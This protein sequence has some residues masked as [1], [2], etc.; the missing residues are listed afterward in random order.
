MYHGV[1]FSFC[2]ALP[3][4]FHMMRQG[5][6]H[7]TPYKKIKQKIDK[8]QVASAPSFGLPPDHEEQSNRCHNCNVIVK[9]HNSVLCI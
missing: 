2:Q 8:M 6:P 9:T 3:V 4:V 5:L 1:I 7:P